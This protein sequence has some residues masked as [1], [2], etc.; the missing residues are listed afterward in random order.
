L[1]Q[2][3][4]G[5]STR[6]PGPR[7][8]C[9]DKL[10]TTVQLYRTVVLKLEY[11]RLSTDE[12]VESEY[13]IHC[14]PVDQLSSDLSLRTASTVLY[15]AI[16][17][18]TVIKY[19][20]VVNQSTTCRQY[21][22][23]PR[24]DP[25]THTSAQNVDP[26]QR[27]PAIPDPPSIPELQHKRYLVLQYVCYTHLYIY[28]RLLLVCMQFIVLEYSMVLEYPINKCNAVTGSSTGVFVLYPLVRFLSR[29]CFQRNAATLQLL[30]VA[31]TAVSNTDAV[32]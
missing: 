30:T 16:R 14:T 17:Y 12:S 18:S 31:P 3:S 24:E 26:T 5:H 2:Y 10:S 21:D 7:C 4:V 8:S 32:N 20:T 28:S 15:S 19:C 29:T 13:F 9:T 11:C 22:C 6:T 1:Y 25:E 27:S 23:T